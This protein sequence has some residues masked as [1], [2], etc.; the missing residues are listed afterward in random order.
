MFV[1]RQFPKPKFIL[2]DRA[3]I[4]LC[5]AI[6]FWNNETMKDFLARAYRIVNGRA[7]DKDLN[8]TNIHACIAHVL[9]VRLR[10]NYSHICEFF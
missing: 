9:I 1:G 5:A 6:K 7:T 8:A 4:F 3:Q 10:I 2:S